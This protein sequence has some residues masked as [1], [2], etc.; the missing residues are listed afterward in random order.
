MSGKIV[1]GAAF[2]GVG[3]FF[4]YQMMTHDPAIVPY[5]KAQVQERLSSA[6]TQILRR[7]NDGYITIWGAGRTNDGVRLSMKYAEDAPQIDCRAV[8]TELGPN[9]SR[10]VANCG[11]ATGSAIGDTTVSMNEPMF[12]EHIQSKLHNKEF[13]R[14]RADDKAVGKVMR[15]MGAMQR[16]A[17]QTADQMQRMEAEVESGG[18]SGYYE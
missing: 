15:N 17:L 10:V 13:N 5:S 12:D 11:A 6:R 18:D 16:E 9:Q 2:L 8:I 7:D 1:F 14:K 3:G 4:G